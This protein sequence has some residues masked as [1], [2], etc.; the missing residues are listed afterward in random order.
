VPFDQMIV[1]STNLEPRDL[2]DDA[3]LRRIPY[4]IE[5]IDPSPQEFHELFRIFCPKFG[6]AYEPTVIDYLLQTH[7][8]K[9][10]RRMK[11]CHPRDLMLQIRNHCRYQGLQLE[12][13][14]EYFDF[15][16]ETYFSIV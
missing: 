8:A 6:F 7:Y 3:F 15:A 13:R 10:K 2:V 1:F 4:K 5:V 12:L 9:A 14:P 16:C 11:N